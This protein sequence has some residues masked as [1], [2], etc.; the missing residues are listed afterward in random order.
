M[1]LHTLVSKQ[2]VGVDQ[3]IGEIR[4]HSLQW[5]EQ[6]AVAGT[7][8]EL[9]E[10][11][12]RLANDVRFFKELIDEVGEDATRPPND[13]A[14]G[15]HRFMITNLH[16]GLTLKEL[17]KFLG[18]SEKYCSELFQIH[19]GQRFSQYLR[20]LRLD[21]ARRLL[22]IGDLPLAHIAQRL[23]FSDQFA[24]SH[25]FKRALGY[26]P[27]QFRQASTANAPHCTQGTDT[28]LISCR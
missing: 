21:E 2:T 13:L 8:T 22:E 23:G 16:R 18:Y 11:V 3:L 4:T 26:S 27:K 10:V 5:A 15:I 19:M 6:L 28:M 9:E 17:A 12:S 14:K 24:F 20:H 1:S 7:R 25:F